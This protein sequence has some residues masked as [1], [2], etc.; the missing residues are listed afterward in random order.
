[1]SNK[2]EMFVL[3]KL[4]AVQDGAITE[5]DRKDFFD[6]VRELASAPLWR[7]ARKES[8]LAKFERESRR[9]VHPSGV[10]P[11]LAYT[12]EGT[13]EYA[14]YQVLSEKAHGIFQRLRLMCGS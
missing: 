12:V 3:S 4:Q 8:G 2:A 13:P 11:K 7:A 9:C 5:R 6:A 14:Q 10:H 1:M